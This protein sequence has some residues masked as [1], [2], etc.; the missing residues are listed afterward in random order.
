MKP[1]RRPLITTCRE[2]LTRTE[3]QWVAELP[4]EG[5]CRVPGWGER[6]TVAGVVVVSVS[7]PVGKIA[8]GALGAATTGVTVFADVGGAVS[9][10]LSVGVVGVV[11]GSAPGTPSVCCSTPPLTIGVPAAS[12]IQDRS[13]LRI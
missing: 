4:V 8:S 9:G 7:A 2:A 13:F 5:S 12:V 6:W 3:I 10:V 11:T 1:A